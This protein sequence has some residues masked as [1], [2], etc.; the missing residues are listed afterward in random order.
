MKNLMYELHKV[1]Y[2]FT[3]NR[4]VH[5]SQIICGNN[6]SIAIDSGRGYTRN[7]RLRFLSNTVSIRKTRREKR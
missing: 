2:I 6:N 4:I 7:E 3:K 1:F 5:R